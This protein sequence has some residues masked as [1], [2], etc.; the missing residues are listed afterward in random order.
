[1]VRKSPLVAQGRPLETSSEGPGS[2]HLCL[3]QAEVSL[4][5]DRPARFDPDVC[6]TQIVVMAIR[7]GV[8]VFV[9][10]CIQRVPGSGLPIL[11]EAG[12]CCSG[13]H[14]EPPCQLNATGG[15]LLLGSPS[16]RTRTRQGDLRGWGL[17][18]SSSSLG[19]PG[20]S[21]HRPG[22]R[23]GTSPT[24]P[25]SGATTLRVVEESTSRGPNGAQ[26]VAEGCRLGVWGVLVD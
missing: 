12:S 23:P 6:L 11:T 22:S 2:V 26:R 25:N 10:M 21:W 18:L 5:R 8:G 7:N 19:R 9:V 4:N 15:W 16:R 14:F 3:T 1:M 24:R 20:R 13:A 17:S